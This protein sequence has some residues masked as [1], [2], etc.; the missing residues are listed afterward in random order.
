MVEKIGFSEYMQLSKKKV[1][2]Y[3]IPAY[4]DC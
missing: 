2:G 3:Q 1:K 4:T